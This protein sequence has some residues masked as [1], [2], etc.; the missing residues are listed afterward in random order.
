MG[1]PLNSRLFGVG[2]GNQIKVRAKVGTN[3]EGDGVITRQKGSNRFIVDVAGDVGQCTLVDKADGALGDNEMTIT[4]ADDSA[5]PHRIVKITAHKATLA[6]GTSASWTF[7][8]ST[9]DGKVEMDEIVD[10]PATVTIAGTVTTGAGGTLTATPAATDVAVTYQW[11]Q[12]SDAGVTFA[13]LDGE[14]AS[15]LTVAAG[16]TVGDE[17]RVI[18]SGETVSNTIAV[19]A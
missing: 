12:S 1:R 14:T 2:S 7:V 16:E 6:D 19:T 15:T 10:I 4:V 13:D 5:T 11:Q 3:A 17:F 8:D 18:A 9:S